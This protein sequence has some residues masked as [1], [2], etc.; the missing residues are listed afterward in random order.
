MRLLTTESRAYLKEQASIATKIIVVSSVLALSGLVIAFGINNELLERRYPSPREWTMVSR[1]NYRSARWNETPEAN[2]SGLPDWAHT[3]DTYRG[4]L[5]RLEDPSKDGAGL[6]PQVD[7][8]GILVAG[9]GPTGLDISAKD[10]AWRQGYY[11]VLRGAA[12]AAENLDGWRRDTTRNIAFPANVV[13]G[14]SNPQPRPCPPGAAK[15]PLEENCVAAFESPET[16]YMKI[17][18]T[19]GFSTRQR[20]DAALAYADW[21]EFKGLNDTAEEMYRW[22]LD[23]ACSALPDPDVRVVDRSTGIIPASAPLGQITPN[24]LL[25]TTALATH[26]ARTHAPSSALPIFLSVLRAR[27]SLPSPF[28]SSIPDSPSQSQPTATLESP[29]QPQPTDRARPPTPAAAPTFPSLQALYTLLTV[30]P[31]YPPP[32]PSGDT[33]A[34]RTPASICE[35]AGLMAYIGEVLFASTK[36]SE[37]GVAWTREA[38]DVAEEQLDLS[39][40]TVAKDARTPEEKEGRERCAECLAMGRENWQA[41]VRSLAKQT[42]EGNG[43]GGGK[44]GWGLWRGKGQEER[45]R[46]EGEERV[47]AERKRRAERLLEEVEEEREEGKGKGLTELLF[48]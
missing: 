27:R 10:Y 34:A 14:P 5:Q 31:A 16:Y 48:A 18:T 37:Q 1:M 24:V 8:E 17:L 41:M 2:G 23:I 22:G 36:A 11:E 12:R 7:G 42:T 21:C 45:E 28:P 19:H 3:G 25:A 40:D 43:K 29:P 44:K 39:I 35:E 15:A 47:V 30:P 9:V 33:P 6:H 20:L 32:P 4:L 46:W 38:V 13:L 26:H